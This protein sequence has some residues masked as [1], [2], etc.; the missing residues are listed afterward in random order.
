MALFRQVI[1]TTIILAIL[2]SLSSPAIAHKTRSR[3]APVYYHVDL[4]DLLDVAGPFQTFLGYLQKTSVIQ[5]FQDQADNTKVGITMFVPRD[6]A[7]AEL[8]KTRLTKGHIKSL[9]LY[10]ALPKF[11]TA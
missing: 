7:F 5:T 4:A 10:H 11:Y 9:L 2:L 6:S 1:L 8:K 3:A